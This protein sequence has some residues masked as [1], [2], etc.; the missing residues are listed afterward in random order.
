MPENQTL[1]NVLPRTMK[2]A[3][4]RWTTYCQSSLSLS[5]VVIGGE[6]SDT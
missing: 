3:I 6:R 4:Q 1:P 2:V 5:T